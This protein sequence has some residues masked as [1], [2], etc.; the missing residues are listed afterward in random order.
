MGVAIKENA[1]SYLVRAFLRDFTRLLGI[2]VVYNPKGA[3]VS[4]N[5]Y[6]PLGHRSDGSPPLREKEYRV[7]RHL[8]HWTS[9][10]KT[11][12]DYG[13]HC[14]YEFFKTDPPQAWNPLPNG[15]G[16]IRIGPTRYYNVEVVYQGA[17]M[18]C[19]LIPV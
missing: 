10:I 2:H 7:H 12:T 1:S 18:G 14:N 8:P 3:T 16:I 11:L 15:V 13:F 6:I 9:L 19:I 17:V 5:R 4:I